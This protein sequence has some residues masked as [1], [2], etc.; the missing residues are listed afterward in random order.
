MSS[1]STSRRITA[2]PEGLL[3]SSITP[4]PLGGS[5][6]REARRVPRALPSRVARMLAL[7]RFGQPESV[8]SNFGCVCRVDAGPLHRA[9]RARRIFNL[10]PRSTCFWIARVCMCRGVGDSFEVGVYGFVAQ[11]PGPGDALLFS[12][13][14]PYSGCCW[15]A[16]PSWGGG[17]HPAAPARAD[18]S[19]AVRLRKDH[20]GW[21]QRRQLPVFGEN[22][23]STLMSVRLRLRS[24]RIQVGYRSQH[25]RKACGQPR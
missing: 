11:Q 19:G 2:P 20:R 3:P 6:D 10:D 5:H 17:S 18:R 14:T 9:Q 25:A 23:S 1:A 8:S 7:W 13:C 22:Y 24:S 12:C 21:V 16:A 15:C 4:H